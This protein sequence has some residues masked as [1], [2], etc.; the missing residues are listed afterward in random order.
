MRCVGFY[1]ELNWR[2]LPSGF[3][4]ASPGQATSSGCAD[5][6]E[7]PHPLIILDSDIVR[8]DYITLRGFDE[9]GPAC[10]SFS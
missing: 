6:I 7:H 2:R 1:L 9:D 3:V 8:F 5:L 4:K 10:F